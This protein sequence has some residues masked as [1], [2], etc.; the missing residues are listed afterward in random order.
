MRLEAEALREQAR[1]A[2]EHV[3]ALHAYDAR[4][5]LLVMQYL[6]PPHD[7]LRRSL[8][9]GAVYPHLAAHLASFLART[10]FHTSLFALDTK[11]WR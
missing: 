10:L 11:A 5:C 9:A 1:H 4:A 6:P 3:P 2:P 8:T 7:V